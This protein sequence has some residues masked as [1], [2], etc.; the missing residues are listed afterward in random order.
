M[1]ADG[2]ISYCVYS[3]AVT[4][5]L[6]R[7]LVPSGAITRGTR[8]TCVVLAVS[9]GCLVIITCYLLPVTVDHSQKCQPWDVIGS[10][11][12]NV[13]STAKCFSFECVPNLQ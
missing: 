5:H 2:A 12:C 9:Q 6:A 4:E 11:A 8:D 10:H 3:A 1:T 7:D 13:L